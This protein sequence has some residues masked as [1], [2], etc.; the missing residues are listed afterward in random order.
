MM[1]S[2]RGT[3]D[4]ETI[5]GTEF[6]DKIGGYN[7]RDTIYGH[8]GNDYINGGNGGDFMHGGA[9]NDTYIVDALVDAIFEDADGGV[10]TVIS[11]ISY[12]LPDNVEN[13]TLV[14]SGNMGGIG[15]A[16]AN[17]ITGTA[18][19]NLLNGMGGDDLLIGGLGD[20]RY[21]VDVAGGTIIELAGEGHEEVYASVSFSLTDDAHVETMVAS[22]TNP[23]A[24]IDIRGSAIA[25]L[26]IG[27]DGDNRIDGAG[28]ADDMQGRHGNDTYVVDNVGDTI[29]ETGYQEGGGIDTVETFI[30]FNMDQPYYELE[31]LVLVGTASINGTGN[32]RA[33]IMTGNSGNNV[34]R[35]GNGLDVLIGGDG[36]DTLLGGNDDDHM[37]GGDGNDIYEVEHRRDQTIEVAGGG[38]DLV[39]AVVSHT[40]MA[41]VERLTL[42]GSSAINGTG[43]ELANTIIGNSA[44]NP[45]NGG[46]GAD[47]LTGGLG[48]D[49]FV[50]DSV[51]GDGNVDDITDFNVAADTI[52][53]ARSVF[54]G[55]AAG[56]LSAGAFHA[57]TEA[58][59]ADDR[60][61]YDSA[62][63]NIWY[64]A[65][66]SGAGEAMLFAT[67]NA[68]TALTSADFVA[69]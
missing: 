31:N 25:N 58:A 39:K 24:A 62:T 20:D 51:L 53:L 32:A 37:T 66:G 1:A 59:D 43:N 35:A 54:G 60:I 52:R 15:N 36:N 17:I 7:G 21:R 55:I 50:F 2:I 61:V 38:D 27:N 56:E 23:N 29:Y 47:T 67:A 26:M 34:L 6:D 22:S 49:G 12:T 8:G 44:A 14:G 42:G 69:F 19:I 57:G 65:D 63:G 30:N 13:L 9:G 11:E 28:G 40:L 68:G 5:D 16:G 4:S 41:N 3:D 18:G 10:D 33:N 64:D 46:A 48:S 45:I